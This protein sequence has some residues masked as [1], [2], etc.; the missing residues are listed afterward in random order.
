MLTDS[1]TNPGKCGIFANFFI[2]FESH[3]RHTGE[4][5]R[6]H[7]RLRVFLC[8]QGLFMFAER[9]SYSIS[10]YDIQFLND[11]NA[12]QNANLCIS[13]AK[14]CSDIKSEK[15]FYKFIFYTRGPP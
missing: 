13:N 11:E 14:L 8:F 4:E 3:H 9:I 6:N 1:L 15:Y 12:N 5:A 2:G 10:E 7:G